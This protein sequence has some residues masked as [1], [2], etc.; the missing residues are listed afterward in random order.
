MFEGTHY[1][2]PTCAAR[3]LALSNTAALAAVD[4]VRAI[5]QRLVSTLTA[6]LTDGDSSCL[7]L[8]K[9][10]GSSI[11]DSFGRPS[12]HCP[13]DDLEAPHPG[14]PTELSV[15]CLRHPS[16]MIFLLLKIQQLLHL[17]V[18]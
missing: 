7:W 5:N 6:A 3:R 1:P 15:L 16:D 4:R 17:R 8:M 10:L 2:A 14:E 11:S 12:I 18:L 9:H 13:T